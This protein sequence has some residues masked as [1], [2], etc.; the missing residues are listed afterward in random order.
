MNKMTLATITIKIQVN[1]GKEDIMYQ[2]L[3]N[4]VENDL[5][6]TLETI[7]EQWLSQK[8]PHNMFATAIAEM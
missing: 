2:A 3:S 7:A 6:S 4:A 1:K 8:A 5:A